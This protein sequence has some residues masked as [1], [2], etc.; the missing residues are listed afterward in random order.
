MVKRLVVAVIIL[1][2]LYLFIMRSTAFHFFLLISAT[3]LVCQVEF[4]NVYK[5][6]LFPKYATSAAGIVPIYM[7][8][9]YG[10]VPMSFMATV[11]L[12]VVLL[13]LFVKKTAREALSDVAPFIVSILYIPVL[14]CYFIKLRAIGPELIVFLFLV[15]W[16]AD[17]FALYVGKYFGKRKLYLEISPNK[18]VE[19]AIAAIFGAIVAAVSLRFFFGLHLSLEKTVVIGLLLGVVGIVGDLIESMFK[20]DG[21]VKDSG[22]LLPGHGGILDK[23]DAMLPAAPVLYFTILMFVAHMPGR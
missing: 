16:C 4:L 2:V 8:Y 15:I 22:H 7:T 20:R 10:D 6:G 11:F 19:G 17:T 13:R 3:A 23:I 21:N 14:L 1:P 9:K 5:T 18:T 12:V